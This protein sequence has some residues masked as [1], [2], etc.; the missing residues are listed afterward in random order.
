[1]KSN[2]I[3]QA[4][5]VNISLDIHN[6]TRITGYIPTSKSISLTNRIF[7][8]LL[9]ESSNRAFSIAAPYGSGKSSA[10]LMWALAVENGTKN[11]S[12]FRPILE[13]FRQQDKD[14]YF[15]RFSRKKSQ[16]YSV[17]LQGFHKSITGDL[18]DAIQLSA[19]RAGD[20]ALAKR[21]KNTSRDLASFLNFLS[22]LEK[23]HSKNR[24]CMLIVWDEFGKVL[25][26]CAATGDSKGLLEIQS[27]A[28]FCCRTKDSFP[29]VLSIVLHQSFSQYAIQL[30]NHVR[31]EWAKIEGRF[32]QINYIEDSKEIYQLIAQLINR[33]FGKPSGDRTRFRT[34]A[35][36]CHKIG[37]FKEFELPELEDLLFQSAPLTPVGLFL[38]PRI[39][40]RVAQNERTLFTFIFS[41]EPR[42]LS[43]YKTEE[44]VSPAHLFDFFSDLM[45]G[46]NG[47][48]GTYRQWVETQ[49][50][51][52]KTESSA[53]EG[54]IKNLAAVRLGLG[55]ASVPVNLP[56]LSICM[57][58]EQTGTSIQKTI[59]PL[60]AK[61]VV[62]HKKLTN[63][64][65][66]WHGSDVDIRGATQELRGRL[67]ESIRLNEF[68]AQ[69]FPL[70]YRIP[71]R[72]ND[73]NLITRFYDGLYLTPAEIDDQF[74]ALG[75][76]ETAAKVDG[77]ILYIVCETKK[78]IEAAI[79]AAKSHKDNRTVF[80]I[81]SSPLSLRESVAELKAYYLLMNDN[82]FI[83]S[84][85]VV[86]QELKYLA[87]ESRAF[88]QRQV[89]RLVEP[90][91]AGPRFFAEGKESGQIASNGDLKRYLSQLTQKVFPKTPRF[92][93]ELINRSEPTAQIVNAR[94]KL[95]RAML[96]APEQ[97]NLAMT[98]YGPEVSI[99][100]AVFLNNGLHKSSSN[101]AW[102]FPRKCQG[103]EDN[104][105]SAWKL[106]IEFWEKPSSAAKDLV[107]LLKTL[108]E[109][110]YGIRQGV[111]SLL[112]AAS[113][114]ASK[115]TKNILEDGIFIRE[116]QD[117]TFERMA[118]NPGVFKVQIPEIR[119]ELKDFVLQVSQ[120]FGTG[121]QF[122]DP[123]QNAIA[124]LVTWTQSL[125]PVAVERGI[126]NATVDAF[127]EELRAARDPIKFL[128]IDLCKVF[129][130]ND[131]KA[132][133]ERLKHL[134][135]LC[136]ATEADLKA[137]CKTHLLALVDAG[138][139]DDLA[140]ALQSWKTL[141]PGDKAAYLADRM[142]GGF[143]SRIE[144]AY[145]NEGDLIL[146]LASHVTGKS[147]RFWDRK[148]LFEFELN[149]TQIIRKIEDI[150]DSQTVAHDSGAGA[151]SVPWAEKRLKDQ[152]SS[153]IEK[154][155]VD[156]TNRI[157]SSILKEFN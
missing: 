32:E 42:A 91:S 20:S 5:A 67:L 117:E 45:A 98:G 137:A 127:F 56:L 136:E 101:G 153:L 86:T 83:G 50:A 144:Q 26:H 125:P 94:K 34:L 141:L 24:T 60:I 155:G 6:P 28:E 87:D 121:S 35:K 12:P 61:K 52:K 17:V 102:G 133:L 151:V 47:I 41:D 49:M 89:D 8:G 25:E 134:K 80:A 63:E 130:S 128:E 132:I 44:W 108:K 31:V 78:E 51:L 99:F 68:L 55:Q 116:M 62:F 146:S 97:E 142:T 120:L 23:E 1:M 110:P 118:R 126:H 106:L 157:V 59:D 150:A 16:G 75:V 66:I 123:I 40:A 90:S 39:S 22:E 129:D 65:A 140:L 13:S 122:D 107:F 19:Q 84:D 79:E 36:E 143:L 156:Q 10:A 2:T 57:G 43:N 113:Y 46:D 105:G 30:P 152:L 48:G 119:A 138:G 139:A 33:D 14:N 100:R 148:G 38:L 112:L 58:L 135:A 104:L 124:A 103:L 82:D 70:P 7:A 147:L 37:L 69:E 54:L 27:I 115:S 111:I 93:N 149:A 21:A 96:T 77:R 154:I 114:T 4:K 109:P 64:Y 92:N 76:N 15:D 11:L 18:L 72:Y 81:P 145:S 131:R 88:I 85:P 71:Q 9:N 3:R 74:D 53:E 73:Q 29:I 95:I